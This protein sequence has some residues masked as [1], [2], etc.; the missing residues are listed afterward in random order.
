MSRRTSWRAA[1]AAVTAAVLIQLSCAAKLAAAQGVALDTGRITV[2]TPL[3]AGKSYQLARLSVR[4]PGDQRTR[5]DL[6]ATPMETDAHSPQP[7]WISFSPKQVTVQ[8][9]RQQAVSVSIRIPKNAASGRYEVLV[10]ANVAPTADGI[11]VAAGA[12]ARLTFTV[13]G[14]GPSEAI[15]WVLPSW[16]PV[17]ALALL[18][19]G[20]LLRRHRFRLRL[21]VERR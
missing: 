12:A 17:P 16:W 9:G 13:A 20:L 21:P 1:V 7:S 14:Q 8:A 4:N 18:G 3:V 11:A 6:V 15:V 5:Y 2:E 10:G 19:T